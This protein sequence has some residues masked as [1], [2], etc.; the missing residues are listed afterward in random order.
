M[1]YKDILIDCSNKYK[2]KVVF[3]EKQGKDRVPYSYKDLQC[4]VFSLG[5][6]MLEM[7]LKDKHIAIIGENSYRW[8]ISYLAI[9]NGVGV[10]VPLDK[11]LGEKQLA[12]LMEKAD[13]SVVIISKTFLSFIEYFNKNVQGL[14][15]CIC[16]EENSYGYD[17]IE[18]LVR[19]GKELME[20]GN[21]SYIK[22]KV[23][24]DDLSISQ[25][26]ELLKD[27][28][29]KFRNFKIK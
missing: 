3:Y 7:G 22:S 13:I 17:D 21:N 2:D 10:A 16:I 24:I 12:Q 19:K 26:Y 8:I 6:M 27:M 1:D 23:N 4:N 11:E 29:K 20:K 15:C 25:A 5:T 28:Q 14:Q 9:I 18:S